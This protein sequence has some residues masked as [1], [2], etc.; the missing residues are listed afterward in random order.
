MAS[1]ESKSKKKRR[2]E[3][4]LTE[5]ERLGPDLICLQEANPLPAM[6]RE[7]SQALHMDEIHQVCN[8]GVRSPLFGLPAGMKSGMITLSR[9]AFGLR[10]LQAL[11]LPG[12]GFGRCGDRFSFQLTEHRYALVG[13][14]SW[15]GRPVLLVNTHLHH[16]LPF[17]QKAES[18]LTRARL[19]NQISEQEYRMV[20][21]QNHA[22]LMRRQTQ[23][24]GLNSY[25]SRRYPARPV[26]LAGDMNARPEA[27]ELKAFIRPGAFFD[28]FALKGPRPGYTWDPAENQNIHRSHGAFINRKAFSAVTINILKNLDL[29]PRRI[30][31]ILLNQNFTAEQISSCALFATNPFSGNL[32]CSDHFGVVTTLSG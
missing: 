12:S 15:K 6:A 4:F 20:Y 26:I 7:I 17:D 18:R 3:A 19:E 1:L 23:M 10:H 13:E 5:A 14:I 21:Q 28:P 22:G 16:T 11:K 8:A 29:K 32:Y 27:P 9:K 24:A 30:D 25:L 2:L 31:Y